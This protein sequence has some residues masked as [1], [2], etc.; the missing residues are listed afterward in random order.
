MSLE[1]TIIHTRMK[2]KT[3][4]ETRL[5]KPRKAKEFTSKASIIEGK[6]KS[7]KNNKNNKSNMHPKIRNSTSILWTSP[8]TLNL[9]KEET[10][11]YMENLSIMNTML[12]EEEEE[13]GTKT[14]I[15]FN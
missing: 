5:E 1:D 11:L 8:K 15:E 13:W 3:R 12:T 7:N 2:D 14:Q 10:N 4:I 6:C 9:R